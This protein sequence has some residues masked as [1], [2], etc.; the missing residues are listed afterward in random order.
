MVPTDESVGY[1]RSSLA[2]LWAGIN[3]H[4]ARFMQMTKCE[5]RLPNAE[6]ADA[7]EELKKARAPH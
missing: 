1:S 5:W 2:G 4:R 7:R 6:L 3:L